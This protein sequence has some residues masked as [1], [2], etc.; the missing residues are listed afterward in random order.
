MP[1][2]PLLTQPERAAAL[3]R[4]TG[5]RAVTGRDAI[6][7]T[8][9]FKDFS[10]AFAFMTRVA[11][12]AEKLDHHP[13]W[14]ERLQP[15]RGDAVDA[16]RRWLDGPRH[17]A[18]R[19]D[20]RHRGGM[21]RRG[22]PALLL[23]RC[24]A[25]AAAAWPSLSRHEV[26]PAARGDRRRPRAR[27]GTAAA[28]ADR[29]RATTCC[30]RMI[31]PTWTPSSTARSRPTVSA[32]SACRGARRWCDARGRRSAG[33]WRRRARRSSAAYPGNSPA[34][35]ITRTVASAPATAC[36]TISPSRH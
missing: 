15:G 23:S 16:R 28:V 4:L 1:R 14:I 33:R 30:A 34:A 12:I 24:A 20:E 8:F 3:A 29:A 27:R 25:D 36:S 5:W 10:E 19:G 21:S 9:K 13:E 18:R 22:R 32:A 6:T 17:A 31:P 26:R 11:L 7:R 35:R 2:P